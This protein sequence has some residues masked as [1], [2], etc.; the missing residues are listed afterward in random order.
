MARLEYRLYEEGG[1]F[2]LLY[3]YEQIERDEVALRFACDY[4]VKE[5]NVYEKTSCAIEESCYV[6]YVKPSED[7]K[8]MSWEKPASGSRQG[9]TMELRE[10]QEFATDYQLVHTYP[11]TDSLD[12]M[13]YLAANYLYIDGQEWYRTSAEIDEDRETFVYYAVKSDPNA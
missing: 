5:G 9:F 11:I 6:I 12:V 2:P 13:L 10:F 7:E 4:L 1:D 3:Y 8:V